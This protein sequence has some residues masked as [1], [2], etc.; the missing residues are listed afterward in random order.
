MA[1]NNFS[2]YRQKT[3][4]HVYTCSKYF[5][6]YVD[7]RHFLSNTQITL[8]ETSFTTLSVISTC[9]EVLPCL[10]PTSLIKLFLYR[11]THVWG[12]GLIWMRMSVDQ[13][14]HGHTILNGQLINKLICCLFDRR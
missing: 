12:S 7:I 9:R 10:Q 2:A 13:Y 5:P 1:N 11:T 8:S 14:K 4:K 6:S 3:H